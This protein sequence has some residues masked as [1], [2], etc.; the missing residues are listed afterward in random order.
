MQQRLAPLIQRDAVLSYLVSEIATNVEDLESAIRLFELTCAELGWT[1][2]KF[3]QFC[4]NYTELHSIAQPTIVMC[5]VYWILKDQE[6][7]PRTKEA[8]EKLLETLLSQI[9]LSKQRFKEAIITHV[10]NAAQYFVHK[11]HV[12]HVV[13]QILQG[14][15][16]QV[17]QSWIDEML[18]CINGNKGPLVWS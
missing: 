14:S 4:K 15:R 2:E 16:M 10:Q 13:T 12:E 1:H 18:T 8:F 11:P 9:G 6:T 3:I 5:S 17:K 7:H